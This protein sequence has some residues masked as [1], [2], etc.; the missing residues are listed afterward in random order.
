MQVSELN[1]ATLSSAAQRELEAL[2]RKPAASGWALLSSEACFRLGRLQTTHDLI[3]SIPLLLVDALS[4]ALSLTVV[5]LTMRVMGQASLL[6][7]PMFVAVTLVL[8]IVMQQMHHLYPACGLTYSLEYRRLLRTV[9][10]VLISLLG[11]I[12]LQQIPSRELAIEFSIFA[13]VFL[14]ALSSLRSVARHILSR[15][16]WWAQ[17]VLLLGNPKSARDM[18]QRLARCRNE[19]LRPMG[20]LYDPE[21]HWGT[22]SEISEMYIGPVTDMEAILLRTG[23]CRVAVADANGSPWQQYHRFQGIPHV[24]LPT[25]LGYHPSEQVRLVEQDGRIAIHCHS[26]LTCVSSLFAKRLLDLT[27]VILSAPIWFPLM[28]L[29]A[30]C[31]KLSDPGPVFYRQERVG[32]FRR[33]FLALK[34]RSMVCDAEQRLQAYLS[35]HPELLTEWQATHKLKQDPRVTAIGRFLRKSSLDELPQILNV[36]WGEMSLVGPRP[37]VDCDEYDREYIE[38]HPEVFEL[39]QMVRPGITGLWQISGRNAL[40]Y[41]QR[42]YL[43]RFY[44][45][46]WTVALDI[47]ILWRTL[48]TALFREGAY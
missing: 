44:L 18:H 12:L 23:T 24:M 20:I 16:D 48:K 27:F 3:S 6:G 46:N 38:E 45:H 1:Q 8:T 14:L 25:E 13:V 26:R 40:P 32:R 7:Q 37:I 43:D 35:A 4:V 34:F 39:Y 31:I 36:L 42:V 29:I 5:V 33:P 9:F 41:K 2:E 19:G 22:D 28:L 15:F 47:F 17:P 21:Q 30:L 10:V 11:G